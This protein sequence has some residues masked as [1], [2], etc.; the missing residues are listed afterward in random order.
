MTKSPLFTMVTGL[1]SLNIRPR[2]PQA[3]PV[4]VTDKL[5]LL[6]IESVEAGG[7]RID[8]IGKV[9]DAHHDEVAAVPDCDGTAIL[10][11]SPTNALGNARGREVAAV[12][13]AEGTLE[14]IGACVD[15]IGKVPRAGHDEIAA[16]HDAEGSA[17]A[18]RSARK[19]P[20]NAS[21]T[22]MRGNAARVPAGSGGRQDA[23][24][25]EVDLA[26][27]PCCAEEDRV[28]WGRY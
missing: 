14:A 8:A 6:L 13:D 2:M 19:R 5:P 12:H 9:R 7:R 10:K 20:G 18:Q 24:V 15:A 16:V 25:V 3:T 27:G 23:A 11:R 4:A 17:K 26:A 21:V 1:P 28:S 22:C